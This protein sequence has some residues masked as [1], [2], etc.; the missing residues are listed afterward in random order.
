MLYYSK[1]RGIR[2]K[3]GRAKAQVKIGDVLVLKGRAG[4]VTINR[5][6]KI[7][8]I[9]QQHPKAI[10]FITLQPVDPAKDKWG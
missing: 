4:G 2:I 3:G 6:M 1:E 8:H 7:T 10:G 9:S 5:R